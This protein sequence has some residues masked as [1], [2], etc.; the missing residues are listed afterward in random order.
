MNRFT[1]VEFAEYVCCQIETVL[2]YTELISVPSSSREILNYTL[3]GGIILVLSTTTGAC[4]VTVTDSCLC[5]NNSSSV[6][7]KA[8]AL[9][10]EDTGDNYRTMLRLVQ[11]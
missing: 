5:P 10:D 9:D 11:C 7:E 4:L 6:A 1:D 3:A 2:E 8:A